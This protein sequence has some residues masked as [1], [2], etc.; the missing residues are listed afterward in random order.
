MREIPPGYDRIAPI[1]INQ[2]KQGGGGRVG[3]LHPKPPSLRGCHL[4][5]VCV[6]V[7][8]CVYYRQ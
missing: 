2:R 1:L 7:C 3:W 6:C 8:V 4:S 5:R